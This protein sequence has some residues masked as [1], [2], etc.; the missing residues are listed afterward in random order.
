MSMLR[1]GNDPSPVLVTGETG[2]GKEWVARELHRLSGRRGPLLAV[3]CAALSPLLV[4]SQL[5]GHARGAFTG[6]QSANPGIFRAAQGGAVLLDEV[7]ELAPEIQ[8]KLLRVLQEKE[9]LGVGETRAVRV[10]ARVIGSTLRDLGELARTGAFRLDLYARL[11]LWELRVPPLRERRADL[12]D[13]IT[14]LAA[15]WHASRSTGVRE[16]PVLDADAVELLLTLDWPENLRGVDR[17][18]HHICSTEGH[19]VVTASALERLVAVE[20]LPRRPGERGA[21]AHAD[22]QEAALAAAGP[23]ARR[24]SA[25]SVAARPD[26]PSPAEL[27]ALMQQHGGSLRAV[28]KALGRDRRQIYRWLEQYGMR[29]KP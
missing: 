18:V 22:Q 2:T 17:L 10:D 28:A 4:E 23:A 21:D 8:A 27:A 15:R 5:F 25:A 6:A 11:S 13:W 12:L 29:E 26:K 16:P 14:R 1:A 19:P 9:V 24:P 3:N 20:R 7:G